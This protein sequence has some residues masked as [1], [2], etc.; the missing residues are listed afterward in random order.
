MLNVFHGAAQSHS[1]A[2]P[3]AHAA[4]ILERRRKFALVRTSILALC[5]AGI[6]TAGISAL[7][8]SRDSPIVVTAAP[9]SVSHTITAADVRLSYVP[10]D[11]PIAGIAASTRDV[12]GHITTSALPKDAPLQ[13]ASLTTTPVLPRGFTEVRIPLASST[14][15]LSC[16]QHIRILKAQKTGAA[17]VADAVIM[18][19]Q[20]SDAIG[21]DGS[22]QVIVGV[23][24]TKAAQLLDIAQRVPLLAAAVSD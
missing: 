19:K 7:A 9:L 1:A 20:E 4:R 16:G 21:D 11:I 3:A 24:A 23:D 22:I 2:M 5:V 10:A 8:P 6:A 13:K 14:E 15:H 12:I 17:P 18:T